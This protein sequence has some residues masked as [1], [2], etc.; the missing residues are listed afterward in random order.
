VIQISPGH[1]RGRAKAERRRS[2]RQ[3]VESFAQASSGQAGQIPMQ[4][5]P[6]VLR[7]LKDAARLARTEFAPQLRPVD[8]ILDRHLQH[9]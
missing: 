7:F 9:K 5:F 2:I 1:G 6:A 8:C 3:N 4:F